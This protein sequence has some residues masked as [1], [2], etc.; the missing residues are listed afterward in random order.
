MGEWLIIA[1]I[2]AYSVLMA[3]VSL[4]EPHMPVE[5]ALLRIFAAIGLLAAG[6]LY[7]QWIVV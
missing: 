5:D 4:A 7:M 6:A 2:L 3:G 1:A